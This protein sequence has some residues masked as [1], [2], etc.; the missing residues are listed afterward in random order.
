MAEQHEKVE[1]SVDFVHGLQRPRFKGHAYDTERN[2]A[3]KMQ[4][5][6]SY[7]AACKAA[8]IEQAIP[9][10]VPVGVVITT[11]RAL[12][13]SRPKRVE[14]EEDTYK[15][16]ADNIAKLVLDALNGIAFADDS[17]VVSLFIAK[18][19]RERR[20][21]EEMSICVMWDSE[22]TLR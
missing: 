9:M 19:P 14:F 18:R 21:G 20:L 12:P 15:P 11:Y 13:K 16:D 3:D 22:V 4:I 8:G 1:F 7:K 5:A 6:L 2:R 10:G 17:Q